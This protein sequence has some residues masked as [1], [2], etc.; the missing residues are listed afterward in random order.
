MNLHQCGN[1]LLR[2]LAA[3]DLALLA[4]HW[5]QVSLTQGLVLQEDEA[6]IEHVHFPLSGV[7]SLVSLMDGGRVFETAIVGRE[8]AIGAFAGL[9]PRKAFTTAVVRVPGSAVVISASEFQMAVGQIIHLRTLILRYI[10]ARLA[11][12]Q[13]TAAC[14]A[15]H[16]LQ[17]RLARWLLQIFDR[18]DDA[19]L[20]ITQDLMAQVLAVRRSTVN[21]SARRLQQAGM[22]RYRRGLLQVL[23]RLRL[24]ETA[25]DCY[26][27]IQHRIDAV[28][29]ELGINRAAEGLRI[30][31]SS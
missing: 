2:S 9:G 21:L 15:L 26:R 5:R 23:D 13:Q 30:Q 19:G 8:G 17:A 31:P 18:S 27:V 28:F 4:P 20:P 12:F 14:N 24:E 29:D 16:P 10:D 7:I 25:C 1:R 22:I 6:P 11:Q 3:A